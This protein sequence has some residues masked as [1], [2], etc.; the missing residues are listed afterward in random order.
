M[1]DA[2]LDFSPSIVTIAYGTNDWRCK[3]RAAFFRDAWEYLIRARKNWPAAHIAV[4]SPI[5]RPD[6]KENNAD[7]SFEEMHAMLGQAIEGQR[8][9]LIDGS[10]LVPRISGLFHD[11]V[12]PNDLGML[13]YGKYLTREIQNMIECGN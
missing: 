2:E 12:H 6:W 3:R 1:L 8:M 7:F 11:G 4:I 10:G 13:L 5:W 9:T